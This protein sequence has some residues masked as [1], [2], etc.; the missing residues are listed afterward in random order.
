MSAAALVDGVK[1]YGATGR[2]FTGWGG[3]ASPYETHAESA[4]NYDKCLKLKRDI[5]LST[6]AF[7]FNLRRYDGVRAL[8]PRLRRVHVV[9]ARPVLRGQAV[10]VDSFKHRVESA[11]GFCA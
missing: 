7:K 6:C 8:A 2:V 4:W 3:A 10:Q 11:H 9:R 5:L 1:R